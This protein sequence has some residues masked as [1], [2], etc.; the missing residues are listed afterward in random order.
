M[1]TNSRVECVV[2]DIRVKDIG[3]RRDPQF[4]EGHHLGSVSEKVRRDYCVGNLGKPSFISFLR[5]GGW[6]CGMQQSAP[7]NAKIVIHSNIVE[8]SGN[9]DGGG[10][11]NGSCHATRG[12]GSKAGARA[13]VGR[14]PVSKSI[15]LV[16]DQR[17]MT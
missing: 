16:R 8:S 17:Q 6:L 10:W 7:V 1:L 3:P 11:N 5:R 9:T 2:T 13:L 12:T 15:H 4:G 14:T